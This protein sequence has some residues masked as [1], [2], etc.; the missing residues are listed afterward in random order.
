MKKKLVVLALAM[1]SVSAI[2]AQEQ[3]TSMEKSLSPKFGIKGGINLSNLYVDDVKDENM[4]VG[5]NLGIYAKI[6]LV[7]GFSIQPELLYSSKGAKLTYDN[8]LLGKGEY[9]FNLNYVEVPVV[10]SN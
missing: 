2:F 8:I 7:K 3:Q 10:G 4:K 6:P 9:R 1:A 5:L